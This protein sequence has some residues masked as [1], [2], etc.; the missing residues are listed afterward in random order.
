MKPLREILEG[1]FSEWL[2]EDDWTAWHAFLLGLRAEPMSGLEASIYRKCTGRQTLPTKP[3]NEAWVIAGRRARKSAIAAVLGCYFAVYP[4]WP[5]ASGETVRVLIVAVSKDQ[6]K[7]VR[8]Y[9]QAILESRPGLKRLIDTMDAESI[10]LTNGIQIQC[11]ANSFRSIRG[12]TV[13]CA[14]FEELAF[15]YDERYSNPDKEVLRAVRPSML[16]VPG[17]LLLGISS[18]YAKRGLLYEKYRTHHGHD[19]AK[20]LV[21]QADTQTMNPQVDADTIAEAYADDPVAAAAEYGGQFRSDLESFVSREALD[22]VVS[23]DLYERGQI[24]DVRYVG[25]CDPSGGSRD[26]FT[27]AIAHMDGT[28]IVLDAVRE[29]KPPFSPDAV[30]EEYADLFKSYGFTSVRGD[31]YS[32]EFVR[33]LFRKRGIEYWVS[34]QS[35]SEIYLAA[36]PAINSGLVELLDNKQL[37]TQLSLLERRTARGGHDSVDHPPNA[38]D[39]VANAACGALVTAWREQQSEPCGIGLPVF[40]E[41]R[42]DDVRWLDP[43]LY[44]PGYPSM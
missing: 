36:L 29:K 16:T 11:V 21:W 35:K 30:V 27:A 1:P 41:P 13:V 17:A 32:G 8:N 43:P 44:P 4:N 15:W 42:D 34:T 18:P 6:A 22:A 2:G 25:F 20:V 38:H 5:R 23:R 28:K 33:E 24:S 19:D 3:F 40:S 37:L 14:I 39:D 31:R 10:T 7:L 9:C 12:P 26:S